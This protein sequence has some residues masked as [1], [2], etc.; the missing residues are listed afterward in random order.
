MRDDYDNP[1][2]P[3]LLL[4]ASELHAVSSV[5]VVTMVNVLTT[6]VK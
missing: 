4:G 6:M 3:L 5:F 1:V 2:S